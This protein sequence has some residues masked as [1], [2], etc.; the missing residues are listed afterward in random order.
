MLLL[1]SPLSRYYLGATVFWNTYI[2]VSLQYILMYHISINTVCLYKCTHT[3]IHGVNKLSLPCHLGQY[4]KWKYG[5]IS[6]LWISSEVTIRP[7]SKCVCQTKI[8][9]CTASSWLISSKQKSYLLISPN[10]GGN[11]WGYWT[12]N[13]EELSTSSYPHML[14]ISQINNLKFIS[15]LSELIYN[16]CHIHVSVTLHTFLK[17]GIFL[18]LS[19]PEASVS[20]IMNLKFRRLSNL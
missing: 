20:Q 2:Y 18:F 14:W 12:K 17:K 19:C 15:A 8:E 16:L 1:F 10:Y 13:L 4:L 9:T 6:S 11:I 5:I 7:S 3:H